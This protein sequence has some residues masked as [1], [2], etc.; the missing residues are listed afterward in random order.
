[1]KV[2]M[3]FLDSSET[4]PC[5]TGW[6]RVEEDFISLFLVLTYCHLET[7]AALGSIWP[8]LETHP[9]ET[10]AFR[11]QCRALDRTQFY[12]EWQ[13]GVSCFATIHTLHKRGNSQS[14][15]EIENM[16][17]WFISHSKWKWQDN[18]EFSSFPCILSLFIFTTNITSKFMPSQ[19]LT[20][21][22]SISS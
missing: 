15:A 8:S 2:E 19:P 9:S 13:E 3:S 14:S 21:V 5:Q 10:N 7:P 4:S 18:S 17:H 11:A 1:M 6:A 16:I 12:S 20:K 22:S